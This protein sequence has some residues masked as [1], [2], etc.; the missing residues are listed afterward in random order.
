MKLC[1]DNI[2][3]VKALIEEAQA[4]G[5]HGAGWIAAMGAERCC[6]G[7]NGIGPEFLK[8]RVRAK[9]TE[10]LSIFEPAAVIHDMR[11]EFADGT[12][13][14]FLAANEEFR[15]NCLVLAE[16]KYPQRNQRVRQ[17]AA[18]AA[19]EILFKFVS[20]DGFGWKAWL[21]AHDR[22]ISRQGLRPFTQHT[23]TTCAAES[24]KENP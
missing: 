19:A 2:A 13:E 11:N 17:R 1:N 16:R 8:P 7:Y 24:P 23:A 14:K 21:E 4:A 6:E 18:K 10:H 12:R 5:L 20:A 22:Y 3:H 15:H 9:V